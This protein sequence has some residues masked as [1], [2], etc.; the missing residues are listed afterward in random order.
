MRR[1]Q[2]FL[3]DWASKLDEFLRFNER[4]V[5]SHAGHVVRDEADRK[6]REEY[7]RFSERRR[8]AIES[9]AQQ[10]NLWDLEETTRRFPGKTEDR[11]RPETEDPDG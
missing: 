5:L 3:S 4:D 7:E 9:G 11:K 8:V 10:G 6:A 1:K 2:V